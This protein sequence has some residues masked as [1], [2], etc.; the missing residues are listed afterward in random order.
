MIGNSLT[1]NEFIIIR[2]LYLNTQCGFYL[3]ET[4]YS[5]AILSIAGYKDIL[6]IS[7]LTENLYLLLLLMP[8]Y[9][10]ISTFSAVVRSETTPIYIRYLVLLTLPT[11]YQSTFVEC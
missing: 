7:I 11:V 1:R 4:L 9:L 8:I 10:F 6:V 2:P 3:R 5:N